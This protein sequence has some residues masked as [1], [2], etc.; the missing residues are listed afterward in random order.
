ME[1]NH[2]DILAFRKPDE[3]D[4]FSD[5]MQPTVEASECLSDDE[6]PAAEAMDSSLDEGAPHT[7]HLAFPQSAGQRPSAAQ[8][9]SGPQPFQWM[10]LREE[11]PPLPIRVQLGKVRMP[12]VSDLRKL[13]GK[14]IPLDQPQHATVEIVAGG[15]VIG[16]GEVV[17]VQ[18]KLAIEIKHVVEA[19]QR[20]SA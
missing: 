9:H 16:Y 15:Q 14:I 18:G 12:A 19:R 7:L 5:G 3:S 1:K 8:R 11:Q 2:R 4:L 10:D 17:V 6:A 20:R 13:S